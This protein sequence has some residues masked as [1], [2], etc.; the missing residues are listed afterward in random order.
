M[1]LFILLASFYATQIMAQSNPLMVGMVSHDMKPALGIPLAGYGAEARRLPEKIDWKLKYPECTLF[2]PSEGYHS[3]IRSKVMALKQGQDHLIF[4]SLD[5]IGL[6]HRLTRD[7][8]KG[9][10]DYGI[11]PHELVL[12]A[13]HTHGGP[14]TLSKRFPLQVIAVDLYRPK[15]YRYILNQVV[16]SIKMALD[17]ME[18]AD[19]YKTKAAINGIQ[20][21][22]WRQVNKFDNTAGFLVAKSRATGQWM[23]G[24][25]N[26]SVHGGS[27]PVGLMLYSSDLNGGIE[28]ELE[29]HFAFKNAL[30]G[31][32]PV[33][34]FLNGAEGDVG[35]VGGRSVEIIDVLS[36]K[37]VDEAAPALI[38]E[39]MT[40][41]EPVISSKKDKFFLGIPASTIKFC[42]DGWVE[43]LP[44]WFKVNLY[45]LMPS[46]S[47]ISQSQVGDVTFLTWPGEPSTQLGWDLQKMAKENGVIDPWVIG[48]AHDYTTYYTNK[49]EFNEGTYDS[50]S[51]LYGHKGSRRVIKAHEKLL[52]E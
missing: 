5:T 46:H 9:L 43:K 18:P 27:M 49:E 22:K 14:G 44:Q 24:I 4:V 26:F 31:K 33:F 52:K 28:H 2:R 51:S 50:C 47:Y 36:K 19:V 29:K 37:F 15:N 30:Q 21:N 39:S 23:G 40:A 16:T 32:E 25:V 17:H 41:V 8:L 3:P 35:A 12:T 10:K 1:K 20:K 42:G 6:E 34:L 45:P 11:K 7:V 13:T 48:L 38:E